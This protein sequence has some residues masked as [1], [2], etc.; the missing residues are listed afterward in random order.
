MIPTLTFL[1]CVSSILAVFSAFP[2]LLEVVPLLPHA[3]NNNVIVII[4]ANNFSSFH[5]SIDLIFG[6]KNP[7]GAFHIRTLP[8]SLDAL[9]KLLLWKINAALPAALAG[10]S[11]QSFAPFCNLRICSAGFRS[12]M[13]YHLRSWNPTPS[14]YR[15]RSGMLYTYRL[16]GRATFIFQRKSFFPER[17]G[18]WE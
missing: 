9:E 15:I 10:E 3:V 17:P 5:F 14:D 1:S 11:I 13:R 16:L 6:I 4:V 12:W 2:W 7:S 8:R 18:F